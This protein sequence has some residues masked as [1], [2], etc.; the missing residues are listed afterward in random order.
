MNHMTKFLSYLATFVA[1]ALLAACGGGGGSSGGNPSAPAFFTTAP[2]DL[3]V[4]LGAS[5]TFTL[6]GG[7]TPYTASTSN[8]SVALANLQG[9]VLTL[10]GVGAGSATVTLRDAAGT[11]QTLAVTVA[12]GQALTVNVPST[13]LTLGVGASS[14]Q[15]YQIKGGVPPYSASSSTPSVASASVT[16]SNVTVTGLAAGVTTISVFDSV[17]TSFPFTV[18]I[19]A[20]AG[21]ALFTT[22]PSPLTLA[23]GTSSVYS[24]GGGTGAY[25]A[26]SSN[27]SVAGATVV[28]NSLTI[29]GFTAGVATIVVR[30]AAGN[31]SNVSVTVSN[32]TM[33]L[34]PAAAS[35]LVGDTLYSSITGGVAPYTTL[36][37]NAAVADAAVGTLSGGVFSVDA[38]GKT[39]RV[40]A[41]QQA[42]SVPVIVT[43]STGSTASFTLTAAPGQPSIQISP[44]SLTISERNT[45]AITLNVLGASGTLAVFSSDPTI[46]QASAS[47]NTITVSPGTQGNA[48]IAPAA[49]G[50]TQAITITAVDASGAKATSVIT[51]QDAAACP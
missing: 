32:S 41:K 23:T 42:A 22:A 43:D 18:T 44:S 33:S 13:T 34:T 7:Q 3:T 20:A 24:V 39:L 16:G 36:V 10:G 37:T 15:T 2:S 8:S 28:G 45:T 4:A 17:G 38:N 46:L 30:D 25:T 31:V 35:A 9:N 21:T 14:A 47:G 40:I 1:V 5:R 26:T 27:G 50:G 6:G 12:A 19:S 49:A 48:C 29:S 11:T 51:I